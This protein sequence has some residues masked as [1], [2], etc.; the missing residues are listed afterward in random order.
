MIDV[1][2]PTTDGRELLLTRYTQPEPE[3]RLLIPAAQAQFA[4][5]ATTADRLPHSSQTSRVVQTFPTNPLIG[6]GRETENTPNPRRRVSRVWKSIISKSEVSRSMAGIVRSLNSPLTKC[7]SLRARQHRIAP[8]LLDARWN[9]IY[10]RWDS[11]VAQRERQRLCQRAVKLLQLHQDNTSRLAMPQ[12]T[13]GCEISDVGH[14]MFEA[15]KSVR[16]VGSI[17]IA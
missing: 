14:H 5:P 2:L 8:E 13:D 17:S 3:L 6:N 11:F 12:A 15:E 1:R 7:L 10:G 4:A 9:R 16:P